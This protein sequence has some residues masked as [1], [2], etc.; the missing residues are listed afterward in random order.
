MSD[1]SLGFLEA[2][3][4]LGVPL[5]V[6]RGAINAG[7]LPAP[8]H[9]H[10]TATLPAEWFASVQKALDEAPGALS[11]ATKQKVPDY[12]RYEGTSA[13]RKYKK[14]VHEFAAFQA[15]TAAAE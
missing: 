9:K 11:R 10:A 7:R 5:R 2:A 1:T 14:R 12:A 4:R 13:W 8:P 3:R 15:K 6:L